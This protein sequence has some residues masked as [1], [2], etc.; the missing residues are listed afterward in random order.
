MLSALPLLLLLALRGEL[1]SCATFVERAPAAHGLGGGRD[2]SAAAAP[3]REQPGS[4]SPQL[5]AALF[6]AG[7]LLVLGTLCVS[8]QSSASSKPATKTRADKEEV[9]V[10]NMSTSVVNHMAAARLARLQAGAGTGADAAS[11]S[12]SASEESRRPVVDVASS[13]S[14]SASLASSRS[15]RAP[16]SR[17]PA[18]SVRKVGAVPPKSTRGLTIVREEGPAPPPGSRPAG[19]PAFLPV[20]A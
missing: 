10:V 18:K 1:A 19:L 6:A 9:I 17:E 16:T 5:S 11:S 12:A 15:F 13:A 3:S 2:N 14:G 7:A 20:V 8:R 4:A